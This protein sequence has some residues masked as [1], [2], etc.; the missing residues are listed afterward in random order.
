MKDGSF[1]HMNVVTFAGVMNGSS[2]RLEYKDTGLFSQLILDYLS[3]EPGVRPFYQA[4]PDRAGFEQAIQQ[5]KQFPINR[6]VLVA[7]LQQQYQSVSSISAVTENISL[8]LQETTF[9]V[10][11]AHQPNLF[12]GPLYFVYKILHAIRLSQ[13]LKQEFPEYNFVPV[14]YMGNEDADFEELSHC[15]VDGVRYQWNTDQSG[16]FGRMVIDNNITRLLQTMSGQLLVQPH[17]K[18]IM[19][20]LQASFREKNTI[21]QATFELVHFLFARFGLVVLVPDTKELKRLMAPVFEQELLH[22]TSSAA[23][24]NTI[25]QLEQH[26]KVQ[27]AGR[28]INLFY[29]DEDLRER[30][31]QV[32]DDFVVANTTIRF[33]REQLL[34]ELHTCPERFSPNVILRGLYQ[35][36]ILPNLVFIGGGGELAYWLELKGVFDTFSVPFPLLVLRNSF[37][38]LSGKEDHKMKDLGFT[39][40][41]WFQTKEQLLSIYVARNSTASLQLNEQKEELARLYASVAE[42]AV[43]VDKTLHA[44]VEALYTK[45]NHHLVELEKKMLRAEKRKFVVQYEQITSLKEKLFPGGGLQERKESILGFY[46]RWGAGLIDEMLQQSLTVEQE[47]TV[48]TLD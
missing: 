31:E 48:L 17:G 45:A 37:L 25:R 47:F 8:L 10:T 5:R 35:E 43:A 41:E 23:V 24:Q 15:T 13:W 32:G 3:D 42:Q 6:Q 28:D 1:P 36:S 39:M 21:Q 16:A 14:Y 33:T 4:R 40:A 30:I 20:V 46:A 9:T 2:Q 34:H 26:Y 12:T 44:H 19:D 7:H 27:A 18:E 38:L 11:T 22:R 29:F